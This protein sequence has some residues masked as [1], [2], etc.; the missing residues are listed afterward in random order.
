M[1]K[2]TWLR[3]YDFGEAITEAWGATSWCPA[4]VHPMGR[5]GACVVI[6]GGSCTESSAGTWKTWNRSQHLSRALLFFQSSSGVNPGCKGQLECNV[7]PIASWLWSWKLSSHCNKLAHE[8]TARCC[9][10]QQKKCV[11]VCKNTHSLQKKKLPGTRRDTASGETIEGW[12]SGSGSW[13]ILGHVFPVKL[14]E[15]FC[16]PK[17]RRWSYTEVSFP[18]ASSAKLRIWAI[19]RS[20]F[21]KGTISDCIDSIYILHSV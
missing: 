1:S 10:F 19:I 7:E 14:G 20:D 12:T 18:P 5:G 21:Q 15:D 11:C 4:F 9:F 8:K 17:L 2:Q 3:S 16:R 6:G 13:D